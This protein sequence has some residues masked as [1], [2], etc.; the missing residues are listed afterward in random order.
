MAESHSCSSNLSLEGTTCNSRDGADWQGCFC[1]GNLED[2]E[3]STVEFQ[4]LGAEASRGWAGDVPDA[5]TIVIRAIKKAC[6]QGSKIARPWNSE[7]RSSMAG[8][9]FLWACNLTNHFIN[10][11]SLVLRLHRPLSLGPAPNF[12]LGTIS[13]P[14]ACHL[15]RFVIRSA[16]LSS[17]QVVG[18]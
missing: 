17:C 9:F 12:L 1:P 11:S 8:T 5:G 6:G 4:G 15:D 10:T 16:L 13:P 7:T 2:K 18:L 3:E 14:I